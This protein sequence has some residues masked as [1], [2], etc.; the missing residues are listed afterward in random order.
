MKKNEKGITLVELLCSLA[1]LSMVLL[2]VSSIQMFSVKQSTAQNE[3]IQKQTDDRLAMN[4]LTKEIRKADSA[5]INIQN[6]ILTI[7]GTK[8][9]LDGT[10]LKKGDQV[11]VSNIKNFT[12]IQ[13]GDKITLQVG[14]ISTTMYIRK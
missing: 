11:L 14:S 3:E 8:Y 4:M 7:D 1:L 5:K 9:F 12:I 6:N 13:N 2:L 10:S